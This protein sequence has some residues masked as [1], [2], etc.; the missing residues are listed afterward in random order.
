[1][2]GGLSTD[3]TKQRD[4]LTVEQENHVI[5]LIGDCRFD[6]H[7]LLRADISCDG[8]VFETAMSDP[9]SHPPLRRD[10]LS[11]MQFIVYEE[12]MLGLLDRIEKINTG[13]NEHCRIAK[14]NI[15]SSVEDEIHRLRGLKLHAWKF[16]EKSTEIALPA[17]QSGPFR[18]IDTGMRLVDCPIGPPN[19][20]LWH[21][22]H[23]SC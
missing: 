4:K 3:L 9:S 17:P 1:M 7:S 8:L 12:T 23:I 15:F 16:Q 19:E 21:K 13:A 14:Q 2:E 6:F 18:E 11:N 5:Q 10:I 20:T 22:G